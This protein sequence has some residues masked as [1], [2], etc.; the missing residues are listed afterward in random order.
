MDLS[1][2]DSKYFIDKSVFNCP[3]CNRRN[4]HYSLVDGGS[5]NWSPEKVCYYFTVKCSSCTL[6][7]FHLS[8]A[9]LALW[10]HNRGWVMSESISD[11]AVFY[12]VPTSHF[13]LDSR[14]PAVLRDLI[15]EGEGCLKSNFLTGASACF[16]K[17][18]YE[19][20]ILAGCKE[21]EYEA[22]IKELKK[23]YLG[24]DSVYFDTLAH[25]Q[26]LTSDKVHEGSW[27][28]WDS[29]KIRLVA[30]ALREAL[31]EIFVEPAERK[32]R[33]LQVQKLR[34]DA[35]KEKNKPPPPAP[36]KSPKG[37]KT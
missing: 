16:R 30:G 23:L 19:L 36:A 4:V 37:E 10:I 32:E 34:E 17:A 12:S 9:E 7:S 1:H 25:V 22:R 6:K 35:F 26:S 15:A 31:H 20:T 27:E 11:D 18:V 5:F 24:V 13:T 2:L 3:F 21:I 8:F 29:P 33:S 28:K 14:I